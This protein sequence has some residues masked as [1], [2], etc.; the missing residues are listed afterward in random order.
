MV[1][2]H[3]RRKLT[4]DEIN[5][6]PMRRYEGEVRLVRTEEELAAAVEILRAESVLGFDTETKPS[7]RKGRLNAPSLIQLAAA[8]VV[9]LVQLNWV[10]FHADLAQVLADPRVL[11]VGVSIHDDLRE[12]QKLH[13]FTPAGVVD[14]GDVARAHKLETQ[15]LRNLAANFFDCRIS[16]GP[17]C[18]NWSLMQ[19]SERQ[20]SYAA[21]DAWIGRE[22]FLRMRDLGLITAPAAAAPGTQAMALAESRPPL[23]AALA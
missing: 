9:F 21:T 1:L 11:K 3:Y 7:F 18:S 5:A 22:V 15:G 14:L 16:K 13:P 17:Q 6:L 20:V 19:L 8:K 2:E 23:Q 12:L 10:S 4:K